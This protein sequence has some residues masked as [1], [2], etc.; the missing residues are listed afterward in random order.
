MKKLC[1]R[2]YTVFNDA[3]FERLSTI[4]VIQKHIPQ[5]LAKVVKQLTV[6]YFN[7]RINYHRPCLFAK[8]LTDCKGKQ[9]EY[10]RY[11]PPT[12]I[13]PPHKNSLN[14]AIFISESAAMTCPQTV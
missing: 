7:P 6:D 9:R 11:K 13:K 5:K 3:Q 12:T 14:Q 4:S 2:A 10:S 1:E 8:L